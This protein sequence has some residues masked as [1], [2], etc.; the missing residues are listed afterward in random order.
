MPGM[1]ATDFAKHALG[2]TPPMPAGGR[3]SAVQTADE[4]AA[5]IAGLIDHPQPELYTIP[6]SAELARR[7]Y[8]DVAAFEAGLR[9]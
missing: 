4:V 1:V 3:P 9:A 5:A 7:Y 6:A 8:Q 2:G